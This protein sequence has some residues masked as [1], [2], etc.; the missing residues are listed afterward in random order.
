M[1]SIATKGGAVIVKD[2]KAAEACSCCG[3]DW[4]CCAD[5]SCGGS[6]IKSVEVSITAVDYYYRCDILSRF[7]DVEAYLSAGVRGSALSGTHTLLPIG[8]P[9]G[10]RQT[11]KLKLPTYE[12]T[13]CQPSIS[14]TVTS[15][16][17]TWSCGYTSIGY[18][19]NTLAAVA[20]RY[21]TLGQ[22]ICDGTN[23]AGYTWNSRG[24]SGGGYGIYAPCMPVDASV[25]VPYSGT[26]ELDYVGAEPAADTRT[27]VIETGS[28]SWSV[29][30]MKFNR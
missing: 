13:Q 28:K 23:S 9:V 24:A 7:G 20:D 27:N 10:G 14:V 17:M 5:Q 2:G 1:T 22:M 15:R 30:S 18:K 6:D 3:G 21:K 19:A 12:G 29:N 26:F 25:F 8:A 4:V 11:F 16:D